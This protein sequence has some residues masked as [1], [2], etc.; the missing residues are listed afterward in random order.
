MYIILCFCFVFLHL[1]YYLLLF[2]MD[3][4]FVIVHSMFSNVYLIH[5]SDFPCTLCL[6]CALNFVVLL[7]RC[8]YF[9][10]NVGI[11]KCDV[12]QINGH[13][14]DVMVALLPECGK[15]YYGSR[16]GQIRLKIV[17]MGVWCLTPLPTI[18]QLYRGG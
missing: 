6:L 17:F 16:S 12:I 4:P 5:A 2:T 7:K 13:I 1:V 14:S 15:W 8:N 9:S 3:C 18:S 11:R 10:F